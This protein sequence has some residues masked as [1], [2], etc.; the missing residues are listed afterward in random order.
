[1]CGIAGFISDDHWLE[2]SDSSWVDKIIFDVE[3]TVSSEDWQCFAQPL[4][5]L[6]DRFENLMS[7]GIHLEL[8]RDSATLDKFHRLADLLETALAGIDRFMEHQGRTEFLEQLAESTRDH[9]W[10]IRKELL[11]NV[12]RTTNL[13][14]EDLRSAASS[15]SVH[16]VAWAVEQVLE[17]VDRLEV[18]GRDSAGIAIQCAW[19]YATSRSALDTIDSVID[20]KKEVRRNACSKVLENGQIVC[21]FVYKVANLVGRLGDN[22]AGLREAIQRDAILW[23]AAS[24][25]E[26]VNIM[27]HTRWAS[28][29]IISLSNCHPVD[30]TLHEKEHLLTSDD[31]FAHFVLNGD[32]DNYK[33]LVEQVVRKRGYEIDPT[34]TTDAKILPILYRLATDDKQSPD[35][36]FSAVMNGCEGS[37]AIVMQHPQH[38]DKLFL[39]QKG[40]GQS[41]FLGKVHDGTILSSEVYGLAARTRRS[42]ALSGTER[43]GTQVTV[44]SGSGGQSLM[45]GRYLDNGQAF[46]TKSE[47]IYIHSRDIFRGSYNHYF[48]KEIHEAPLSV[49]KTI[50][51]KYRKLAGQVDFDLGGKGSFS[52]LVGR[53]RDPGLPLIRRVMVI[54]Q[55]T[56]SVA[57]MGVA[58]LIDRALART[59][60]TVGWR[61]ASEMSG[62][63]SDEPL[64][65]MLLIAISQS[66]T[67]TDTNRTVDVAGS[68]GAW[69]HAIVNRRNSPLVSKANSH[70]YTSDGRDVEMA[71]ASTKAFYSQIAAGKL[72]AL[73]LAK[74]FGSL[75]DEEIHREIQEL[76]R[77]PAEIEWV[78]KQSGSIQESAEKY[79]P[80]SRNW[81]VVGNGPNK[82]AADEIRIKLSELCYKSIPC[83]FTEDKKHIDLSTEPLTIVVANDLPDLL[84]QD[85]AKEVAIFKAHNGKPLVLAAKGET[86]FN[87]YAEKVIEVPA[88]DAGL[89]FVLATVAGHLWG[90]HAAKAIDS[91]AD[92]LRQTRSML[93]RFLETPESWDP[94]ALRSKM[95]RIF[96]VIGSH[97]MN[98]A[99]PASTVAS[100]AT[101]FLGLEHLPQAVGAV[102]DEIEKGIVILNKAVEEMTRPIDTIR[103][104][105]KTV[106]V[107]ISRPQEILPR[108]LLN[109]LEKL[110]ALPGQIR[111]HDRLLLR[112]VAPVISEVAGGL[113]YS[114]VKVADGAT[115]GVST[116]SPW[117]QVIRKFGICDGRS[118]R[119]DRA[120]AIGGS[121]RTTLRVE[122]AIWS[123]GPEGKEKLLLIPL[124]DEE[125][126]DCRGILLFHLNFVPQASVQQ[127]LAVLQGMGNRYHDLIERL[128]ELS[129]PS[130]L[131]E[132]LDKISPHDLIL[133]P[134]EKLIPLAAVK[135]G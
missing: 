81:A 68:Q 90:F 58:Y 52:R 134:V 65:D 49:R 17:N 132:M 39:S 44:S 29:G 53:L 117:I 5:D 55:G 56:A 79:G 100:L 20:V 40:S 9:L 12:Q 82:I 92:E 34:V 47:P 114:V 30:G 4:K 59:R 54:G 85:T 48:E 97:E 93:T 61:K 70:F 64:V 121:K 41:L 21:T 99:L 128:E 126:G 133:A 73:L 10:Q 87:E 36:R 71:V 135:P 112:Q 7:F 32:V 28:N 125:N 110:S 88:M 6:Q 118:S 86:R 16:F 3:T 103:H 75:T 129:Y 69:I 23:Q 96:S 119:Y 74:E 42:Y 116:G 2:P 76:E 50:K 107:G 83:D 106:T 104:Q 94:K 95:S 22:T 127:K 62:F 115:V 57:A 123:S 80:S 124:F 8:V 19:P 24:V 11:D 130:D 66:G 84:V 77:L 109:A 14:P 98:A 67:T 31:I 91:R 18:R 101:Y 120:R 13:M 105:A 37:L 45:T 102:R 89:A 27:A 72:T 25:A 1:M 15:R 26:Q 38:P 51:D 122:S 46:E 35:D 33:T 108:L 111:E 63:F 131:E 78:L 43:G 113:H 60:I